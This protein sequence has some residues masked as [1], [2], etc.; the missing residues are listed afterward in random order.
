M[1]KCHIQLIFFRDQT[2]PGREGARSFACPPEKALGG[3]QFDGSTPVAWTIS[4]STM[5]PSP[6]ALTPQLDAS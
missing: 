4:R 3:S 2:D 1:L 5:V 6:D